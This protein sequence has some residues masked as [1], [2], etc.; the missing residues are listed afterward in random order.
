MFNMKTN[1]AMTKR[2]APITDDRSLGYP[3]KAERMMSELGVSSIGELS[4][5]WSNAELP[6]EL[7]AKACVAAGFLRMRAAIPS[8]AELA[9]SA[10]PEVAWGAA[11]ALAL[12]GGRTVTNPLIRIAQDSSHEAARQAAI[13]ALG[14]LRAPRTEGLLCQILL[15]PNETEKTR[16]FAA[17]ALMHPRKRKN[18]VDKLLLAVNDPSPSVRWQVLAA[19]GTTGDRGAVKIIRK[20]L[21]DRT[22]VP[23]LPPREGTVAF[24]AKR[25]IKRLL[26]SS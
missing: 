1:T 3:E 8:M 24:A 14:R 6:P 12:I 21:T 5:L 26:L 13:S 11:N 16:T 18:V 2:A 10:I 19:L 17:C 4:T 20:Y 15:D 25:A 22:V 7:R 9:D 23:G